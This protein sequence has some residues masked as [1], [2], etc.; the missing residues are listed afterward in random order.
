MPSARVHTTD[1]CPSSDTS[2]RL[3]VSTPSKSVTSRSMSASRGVT[4]AIIPCRPGQR[5]TP[6]R[7]WCPAGGAR[8]ARRARRARPVRRRAARRRHRASPARRRRT[9]PWDRRRPRPGADR[10]P[11]RRPGRR[12]GRCRPLHRGGRPVAHE[13][14]DRRGQGTV[15]LDAHRAARGE[16]PGRGGHG[17]GVGRRAAH[18]R[19]GR[20][21]ARRRRRMVE[22]CRRR[23]RAARRGPA[24]P[25][26]PAG[27]GWAGRARPVGPAGRAPG[28]TSRSPAPPARG[29]DPPGRAGRRPSPGRR[30]TSP[31]RR[32]APLPVATRSRKRWAAERRSRPDVPA[33][34][35]EQPGVGAD[36]AQGAPGHEVERDRHRLGP[37][38][39]EHDDRAAGRGGAQGEVEA[40]RRAGG[41]DDD[42]GADAVDRRRRGDDGRRG[43]RRRC[44]PWPSRRPR[45]CTA[46]RRRRRRCAGRAGRW[47]PRPRRRA[48]ARRR[49]P[50]GPRPSSAMAPSV[51]REAASRSA[52]SASG[53]TCSRVDG[54][55]RLVGRAPH[56]DRGAR[57]EVVDARPHGV[58]RA[59]ERVPR[60]VRRADGGAGQPQPPGPLGAEADRADLGEHD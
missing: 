49:R 47:R 52:P 15:A 18:D 20:P 53:C 45:R 43:R 14:G 27:T 39:A 48:T 22:R 17:R 58:D 9:R 10:P 42:V 7:S 11:C 13:V 35:V 21:G 1:S 44:R 12:D 41:L 33:R 28:A 25:P 54:D 57:L 56:G 23:D 19:L 31:G 40:G 16:R 3:S 60:L 24:V 32:P 26:D 38:G 8:S 29:R 59:G 51:T 6:R 36:D 4:S 5:W 50:P 55:Q 46:W 34:R 37:G 30:G 2:T